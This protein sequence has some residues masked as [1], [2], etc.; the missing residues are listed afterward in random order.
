MV[1]YGISHDLYFWLGFIEDDGSRC[2]S[3]VWV[4][5][6]AV[7][8]VGGGVSQECHQHGPCAELSSKNAAGSQTSCWQTHRSF[9]FGAHL[10]QHGS[11]STSVATRLEAISGYGIRVPIAGICVLYF[12]LRT[13]NAQL[14][15]AEHTPRM[16]PT[17]RTTSL[18]LPMCAL[19]I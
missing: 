17:K 2:T 11:P 18:S 1:Y 6:S 3:S 8:S 14:R 4:K 7:D 9:R 13:G 19:L 12:I 16:R 15:L 5:C 10:C